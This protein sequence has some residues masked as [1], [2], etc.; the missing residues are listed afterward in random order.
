MALN[1]KRLAIFAATVVNDVKIVEY[2]AAMDLETGRMNI[3]ERRGDCELLKE[4]RDVVREDRA[5]F[6]NFAYSVQ[7]DIKGMLD[8]SDSGTVEEEAPAGETAE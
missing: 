2:T 1:N 3:S 6:E 8:L 7:D 4:Y 5:E